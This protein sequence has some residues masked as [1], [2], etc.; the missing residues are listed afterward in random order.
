MGNRPSRSESYEVVD[1]DVDDAKYYVHDGPRRV[2][3][4][5][6]S[7]TTIGLDDHLFGL[8]WVTLRGVHVAT[9]ALHMGGIALAAAFLGMGEDWSIPIVT[10]FA[11]WRQR[12]PTRGGCDDDNCVVAP[13]HARLG[14]GRISLQGLVVAFHALSLAWQFAV[15]VDEC[16]GRGGVRAWYLRQL[17]MGRNGFRWFEYAL[18]AP[19]M[20]VVIA[21]V[22]GIVD[23][24]A[25]LA[26]AACTSGLQFFGYVQEIFLRHA[27][28]INDRFVVLSPIVAGF[29]FWIGYWSVIAAAF[30]QSVTS[31]RA[32]PPAEMTAAIWTTFFVMTFMYASFAF[33]LAYDV[34]RRPSNDNRDSR[35]YYA[36]VE[37]LYC[38]F[39]VTSKT[40]LGALL[41]WIVRVRATVIGLEFVVDPPCVDGSLV[42]AIANATNVTNVVANAT[43]IDE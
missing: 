24:Y 5:G 32:T 21:V 41:A 12:D 34:S 35:G 40:I 2:V 22:F 8:S 4:A 17:Q 6:S 29:V 9:C 1:G 39:S 14:G 37:G 27:K 7:R 3:F 11:D 18:S 10:S 13:A 31:S 43:L 23:F 36:N 38:L 28:R 20:T 16:G 33:V 25:L 26:L 42:N 15:L 30:H 19:L